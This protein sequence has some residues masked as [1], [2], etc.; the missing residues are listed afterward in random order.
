MIRSRYSSLLAMALALLLAFGID[1]WFYQQTLIYRQRLNATVYEMWIIAVGLALCIVWSCLGWITLMRSRRSVIVSI[2]FL[3]IGSLVYIY[4][5]L[6]LYFR[7]LPLL[8]SS[9]ISPFMNSG[10]YVA[11][12]G[13][14]HL[15]LPESDESHGEELYT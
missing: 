5:L 8:V 6:Q 4:P 14:L 11:V 13:I 9:F 2:I 12:L 15:F 3:V 10:I 1:K 7:W